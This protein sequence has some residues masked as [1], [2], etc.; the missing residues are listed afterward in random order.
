MKKPNAK[1][2]GVRRIAKT[3]VPMTVH[4][5]ATK[6]GYSHDY[7]R[8]RLREAYNNGEIEGAK[9]DPIIACT[10]HGKTIVL[11]A[12]F[13]GMMDALEDASP[14]LAKKAR[15]QVAHGNVPELQKFIKRHAA[16]TYQI[17]RRWQFW[18]TTPSPAGG[19][20]GG[21]SGG[22]ASSTA[23]ARP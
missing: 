1:H 22:A 18:Y 8:K 11:T 9:T 6:T 15:S 3:G 13:D 14:P 12:S 17:G 19:S 16:A 21:S 4:Q 2:R 7:M 20:S 23:S 5:I 10:V